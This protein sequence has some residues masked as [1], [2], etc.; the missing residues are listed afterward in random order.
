MKNMLNLEVLAKFCTKSTSIHNVWSLTHA[1]WSSTNSYR[2]NS[3]LQILNTWYY[4][5]E[6]WTTQTIHCQS[7]YMQRNSNSKSRMSSN[8]CS[9]NRTL[10]KEKKMNNWSNVVLTT[11]KIINIFKRWSKSFNACW[12]VVSNFN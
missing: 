4:R 7:W 3:H 8:V 2:S 10:Q 6:T 11:N 12:F 1:F 9:I 5:L